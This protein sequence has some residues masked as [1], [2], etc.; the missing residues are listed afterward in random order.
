LDGNG[1]RL[2]GITLDINEPYFYFYWY[3]NLNLSKF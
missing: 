3:S 1:Q 2:Y